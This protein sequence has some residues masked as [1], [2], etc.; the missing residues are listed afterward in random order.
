M[1]TPSKQ[2]IQQHIKTLQTI[3]QSLT[4]IGE[5]QQTMLDDALKNGIRSG[6]HG[7]IQRELLLLHTA[8][9]QIEQALTTLMNYRGV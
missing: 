9:R 5:V 3:S 7:T 6:I 2:N 8:R 4:P 1:I